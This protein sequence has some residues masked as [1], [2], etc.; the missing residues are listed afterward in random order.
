M[1]PAVAQSLRL[2][3]PHPTCL[4]L[5]LV[6][7]RHGTRVILR[8][9]PLKPSRRSYTRGMTPNPRRAIDDHDLLTRILHDHDVAC[10]VCS[11][12]LLGLTGAACPECGATLDVRIGSSDLR[13][14]RWL[15]AAL[16][17]ALG[18]GFL[19]NVGV[20]GLVQLLI[21]PPAPPGVRILLVYTWVAAL[22][23]AIAM[24]AVIRSRRRVLGWSRAGQ[25]RLLASSIVGGTGLA[26]GFFI[27][28][29]VFV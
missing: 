14:G 26:F 21:R 15:G 3:C 22:L 12:S 11:Y 16:A 5:P 18:L 28:L 6:G 7:P 29:M 8:T 19:A 25:N 20:W 2:F 27:L 17:W 13:L 9:S 23:S 10:P 1:P 4:V 24:V